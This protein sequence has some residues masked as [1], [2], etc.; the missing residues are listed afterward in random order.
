M[1][2]KNE[3]TEY[4][5]RY[6]RG[7][8]EKIW[9]RLRNENPKLKQYEVEESLTRMVKAGDVMVH[10]GRLTKQDKELY[11]LAGT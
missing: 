2:L 10:E 8:K 6:S 9:K 5:T 7:T 11:Y 1:E 3:I 4:L